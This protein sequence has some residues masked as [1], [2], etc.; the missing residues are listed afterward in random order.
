MIPLDTAHRNSATFG[1]LLIVFVQL[2]NEKIIKTV[3]LASIGGT[4]S[5]LFTLGLKYLLDYLR[6]RLK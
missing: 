5:Y 6:K 2:Q 1:M 4:A 3:I